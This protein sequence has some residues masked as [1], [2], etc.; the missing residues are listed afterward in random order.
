MLWRPW[1]VVREAGLAVDVEAAELLGHLR[2][3][4]LTQVRALVF[5]QYGEA[6]AYVHHLL[7]ACATE[8]ARKRLDRRC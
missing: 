3:R 2:L 8:M 1:S 4:W 6:S 5:G 7:H